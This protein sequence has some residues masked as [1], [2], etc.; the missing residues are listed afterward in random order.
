[1][2]RIIT[3][4]VIILSLVSLFADVASELLYPVIP[5]YLSSIGLPVVW[6]GV[7]EGV[8]QFIAGLTKGFFGKRSDET[9]KRIPFIRSGY[10]LSAISKPLM[11]FFSFPVWII[12]TRALDRLGKGVR[13]AARDALLSDEATPE[14]KSRVFGFHRGMDT[15]GA[16]IGPILALLFLYFY[17]GKYVPLFYY[18][19]IPGLISIALIF[20]L[21]EK[22]K[23]HLA[24]R[25]GG[26]FSY[27]KYH[28][29]ADPRYRRLVAGLLAFALFNSSDMFLLLQARSAIGDQALQIGT[30][31]LHAETLTIAAYVFYNLVFALSAYPL[32]ALADRFGSKKIFTAGLMIFAIVY[33]G[34]AMSPSITLIFC[35]FFLYGIFSGLTEGIS[36]A[37]ITN[38][39]PKNETATAIGFYT[40]AESIATLIAS[41]TGGLLWTYA[42]AAYA[43]I[44]PAII[45]L[46]VF[47]YFLF[48]PND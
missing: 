20:L 4:T 17:P 35:L 18:A 30:I 41:I 27:L 9:G 36:K 8:A 2:K 40:S 47:I 48:M 11:V 23:E 28:H 45:A 6:I 31:T 37:W 1:M 43:F 10:A 19:F 26:F 7:M 13:T 46:I 12:F 22:K 32:G 44:I 3:R 33:G 29:T 16:T 42:G 21:Q 38:I 15:L 24:V 14:T 34:F 39:A 5:V 25:K